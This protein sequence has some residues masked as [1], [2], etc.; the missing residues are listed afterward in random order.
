MKWIFCSVFV[1]AWAALGWSPV[2]AAPY[3]HYDTQKLLKETDTPRGKRYGFDAAYMDVMTQDLLRHAAAYPPRFDND[4]DR[5]RA[6]RDLRVL[7]RML[8]ASLQDPA[9]PLDLQLRT[10]L[11]YSLQ[12][13]LNVKGASGKAVNLFEKVLTAQPEHPRANLLFGMF[14][15][16]GGMPSDAVGFLE[17]AAAGG[18]AEAEH[19][20]AV[21]WH[22]MGDNTRA[23]QHLKRYLQR[24]P[25]DMEAAQWAKTLA[26]TPAKVKK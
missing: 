8:E 1:T 24:E 17:K 13:N 25:G 14:L 4:A 9:A 11:V 19:A 15:S 26:A 23:A 20:L 16:S 22:E 7:A 21:A 5:Q 18:L 2:L 12:H 3:G 6:L 10:A